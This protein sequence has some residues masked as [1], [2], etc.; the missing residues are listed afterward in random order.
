MLVSVGGGGGGG[1]FNSVT[2]TFE[3]ALKDP[4]FRSCPA[5]TSSKGAGNTH[6]RPT[7]IGL[8]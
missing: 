3:K 7:S 8:E 6:P 1:L 5:K 2:M 4:C